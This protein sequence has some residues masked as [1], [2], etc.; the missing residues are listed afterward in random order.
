MMMVTASILA[1][2][3]KAGGNTCGGIGNGRAND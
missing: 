2:R 1:K 3:I